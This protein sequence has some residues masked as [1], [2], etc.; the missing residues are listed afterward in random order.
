M[1]VF[2]VEEEKF[3]PH[4][5]FDINNLLFSPEFL[6]LSIIFGSLYSIIYLKK[7][8]YQIKAYDLNIVFFSSLISIVI[9]GLINFL[10]DDSFAHFE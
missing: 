6:L 9:A 5:S 4:H 8:Y 2:N 7:E 10:P 3:I 1:K